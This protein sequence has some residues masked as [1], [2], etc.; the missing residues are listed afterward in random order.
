MVHDGEEK[1]RKFIIEW[2]ELKAALTQRRNDYGKLRYAIILL[3]N[4]R[5]HIKH[6]TNILF[7]SKSILKIRTKK[8]RPR[9]KIQTLMHMILNNNHE[10]TLIHSSNVKALDESAIQHEEKT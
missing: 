3:K 5:G 1:Q 2:Q 9:R 7:L 6:S 8:R 10:S 4:A